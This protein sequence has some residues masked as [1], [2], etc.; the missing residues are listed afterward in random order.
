MWQ[1]DRGPVIEGVLEVGVDRALPGLVDEP[2]ESADPQPGELEHR[3]GDVDPPLVAR[4]V[5]EQSELLGD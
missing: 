1:V 2:D 3:Q 5:V 4:D